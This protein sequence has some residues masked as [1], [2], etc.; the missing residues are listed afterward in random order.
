MAC[1][2]LTDQNKGLVYRRSRFVEM[3]N[4]ERGRRAVTK[5]SG[6]QGRAAFEDNNI[7]RS[8]RFRRNARNPTNCASLAAVFS[9]SKAVISFNLIGVF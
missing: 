8:R 9:P 7:I 4:L 2:L 6:A 5:Q 1:T 3:V